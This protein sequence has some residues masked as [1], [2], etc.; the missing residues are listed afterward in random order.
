MSEIWKDIPGFEGYFQ[1]SSLSRVRSLDRVDCKGKHIV[2]RLL[3]PHIHN[4]NVSYDLNKNGKCTDINIKKLSQ[5]IFPNIDQEVDPDVVWKPVVGFEKYYEVSN[6]GKVRT[7][8]YEEYVNGIHVHRYQK[9]LKIHYSSDGYC[10]VKLRD[11]KNHSVHQL[12]ANA[13]ITKPTDNNI[14]EIDHINAIRTDNRVE[15]LRWIIHRENIIHTYELGH[16]TMQG[17]YKELNNNSKIITIDNG[18]ERKTFN[19][20]ESCIDY[21]KNMLNLQSIENSKL[22]SR[23]YY[24][25][26][27]KTLFYG[28][29][30]IY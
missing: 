4:N 26:K 14:Y 21:L 6:T 24:A 23:L 17:K 5:L 11:N 29:S 22:R 15:N 25:N 10:L 16:G 12:V 18:I 28:Y 8:E 19:C 9:E 27:N 3:K 7:K 13:F 30:I 1:F 20:I 2:G